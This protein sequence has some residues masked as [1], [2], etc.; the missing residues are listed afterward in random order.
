MSTLNN[1]NEPI[2]GWRL[3][4]KFLLKT[5]PIYCIRFCRKFDMT[6]VST[7]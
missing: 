4:E 5:A 6:F 7:T 3:L 1:R 2:S